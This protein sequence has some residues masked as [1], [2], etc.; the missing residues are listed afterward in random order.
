MKKRVRQ[1]K[2][3]LW[4]RDL[5][6]DVLCTAILMTWTIS[7]ALGLF[8]VGGAQKPRNPKVGQV[9]QSVEE[10]WNY[11]ICRGKSYRVVLF[12]A[13]RCGKGGRVGWVGWGGIFKRGK[14]VQEWVGIKK[15]IER[16]K[17]NLYQLQGCNP[18]L[19]CSCMFLIFPYQYF[20]D[21]SH[22][23]CCHVLDFGMPG[24]F[25]NQ[26]SGQCLFHCSHANS[27]N[28]VFKQLK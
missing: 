22:C 7:S 4:Q 23:Y 2:T 6:C 3:E 27:T 1:K 18:H 14:A 19:S 5:S 13:G 10:S 9:G 21:L 28:V 26:P 16:Q 24:E 8:W 25:T 12:V 20:S 11:D 17:C 15:C